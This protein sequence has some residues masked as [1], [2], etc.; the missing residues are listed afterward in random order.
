M[1]HLVV[2]LGL[3]GCGFL[4]ED[5]FT[6]KRAGDGIAPWSDLGPV[7]VCLG[8]QYLGPADDPPGG[9][10]FDENVSEAPCTRDAQCGSREACVCGRCTVAY[11]ASASDCGGGR[12]C[13]FSE[14]RCD[15]P[16]FSDDDCA[17]P[18]DAECFNG[19]CRGRCLDDSECQ[20]GEICDSRNYCATADCADDDGCL[21]GERCRVQRVPRQ[22]L[23]PSPL[24]V[25][26]PARQVILWLE[27]SDAVQVAQTAIWRAVSEDGIHFTMSPAQPVVE[28]GTTARSPSVIRTDAGFAMY[29]EVD[30]GAEL[31]VVTSLDGISW[32][33]P[34]TALTG[35]AGPSATR[36]PAAVLLPDG[37][38]AVYYQIGDGA[39]IGLATGAVG[40]A[41]DDRGP[42]LR[43]DDITV[44]PGDPGAPFWDDVE[45][46]QSPHAAL[47]ESADGFSLRIWY[48]AFGRESAD[49]FQFGEVT[50]IPPNYSIGYAAAPIDDP[51]ALSAW[52]YGPVVDRVSAFLTHHDELTPGVAQLHGDD[53]YLL[54]YV[55]ADPDMDAMGPDGPFVIGRLGVMGNGAYS[56]VTGP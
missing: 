25:S 55:E 53:A 23:D 32:S 17:G 15:V 38:V 7:Q 50:P 37:S 29:Y 21:A 40:G 45:R 33:D 14:R 30:A 20:T 35:G 46:V 3:A 54:Y 11:C 9:L 2:L 19:V 26:S 52:P 6:G 42:V 48:S 24:T 12:T 18:G 4:P 28:D 41:L 10:C 39:A 56:E 36:S 27:V 22:V 47:T 31:R 43:P 13:T 5:D 1:K 44:A 51:G 8:N 49:S 34:V 16:C